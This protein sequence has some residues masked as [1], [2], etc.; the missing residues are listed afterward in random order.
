MG[1]HDVSV[2]QTQN[3]FSAVDS[4]WESAEAAR[5]SLVQALETLSQEARDGQLV[6]AVSSLRS[7]AFVDP[8]RSALN[9][10]STSV[11]AGR[12]AVSHV[13]QGDNQM[14]STASASLGQVS[15]I[16]A[17]GIR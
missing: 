1:S 10:M 9:R 3:I 17:P 14:Q 8:A 13:V 5:T 7:E 11:S 4:D 6:Q 16:D 15:P 12:G 2:G